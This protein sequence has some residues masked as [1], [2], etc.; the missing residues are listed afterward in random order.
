MVTTTYVPNQDTHVFFSDITNEAAITGYTAGG[1]TL[2]TKSTSY[3][4]T[5]NE[6]RLIGADVSWTLTGAFR[7]GVLYKDT[8]AA[9]TSPLMAYIDY[10]SQSLTSAVFTS[11]FDQT[12]GVLKITAAV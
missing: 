4:A 6:T 3:D 5:S 9:A 7:Y 1:A 12:L 8:G 11:D 2:G 10:G